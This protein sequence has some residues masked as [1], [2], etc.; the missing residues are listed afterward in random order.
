MADIQRVVE[1][2]LLDALAHENSIARGRLLIAGALAAAKLL[3]VG[4]LA[5][6]VE[7]LEAA[8]RPRIVKATRR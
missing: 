2:A 7:Q 4:E 3:E 6:R 1:I 5:D 8:I